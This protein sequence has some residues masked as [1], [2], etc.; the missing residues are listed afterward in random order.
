MWNPVSV[1]F[2]PTAKAASCSN[3]KKIWMNTHTYIASRSRL[4]TFLSGC[5]FCFCRCVESLGALLLRTCRPSLA[6]TCKELIKAAFG[7]V[8]GWVGMGEMGG[9]VWASSCPLSPVILYYRSRFRGVL[10]P[11]EHV[12]L[13]VKTPVHWAT[14]VFL[15]LVHISVWPRNQSGEKQELVNV[16]RHAY[17]KLKRNNIHNTISK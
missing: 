4:V 15:H 14:G 17:A 12:I 11:V 3:M 6:G 9:G 16:Q 8:W 10:M 5:C 2:N 7:W 13:R 1:F